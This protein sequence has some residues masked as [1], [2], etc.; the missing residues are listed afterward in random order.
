MPSA[1][2]RSSR[3]R[4]QLKWVQILLPRRIRDEEIGDALED[5]HRIVNDPTCPNVRRAVR[6]KVVTTWFWVIVHA[7]RNVTSAILGKKAG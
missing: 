6:W 5:L 3:V 2:A 4:D 7:V 1:S